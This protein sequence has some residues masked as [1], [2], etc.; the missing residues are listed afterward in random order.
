MKKKAF[1]PEQI[2]TMLREAEVLL[3]QGSTAVETAR[4]L[5]ITEQTYYRW[6]KEYGGMKIDQAKRFKELEKENARLKKL[7]ADL[8]LDNAAVK[9]CVAFAY[10]AA[11][12]LAWHDVVAWA[13]CFFTVGACAGRSSNDA[14]Q[15]KM[16]A[17][18]LGL[19]R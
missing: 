4:K 11:S 13:Y 14:I 1:T 8:S 17:C 7:V 9:R 6:R 12:T 18:W 10:P 2:I 16:R 3:S 5:G 19:S 15:T